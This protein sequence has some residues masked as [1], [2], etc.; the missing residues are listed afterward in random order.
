MNAQ[1]GD[2]VKVPRF[3]F[4]CIE[5][6]KVSLVVRIKEIKGGVHVVGEVLKND[7]AFEKSKKHIVYFTIGEIIEIVSHQERVEFT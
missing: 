3:N 2:T 5:E 7:W 1:V 6:D 4:T